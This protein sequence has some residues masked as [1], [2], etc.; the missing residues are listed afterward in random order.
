MV[1]PGEIPVPGQVGQF[2][3]PWHAVQRYVVGTEPRV[4]PP[5]TTCPV[6]RQAAQRPLEREASPNPTP[7]FSPKRIMISP[8]FWKNV[9]SYRIGRPGRSRPC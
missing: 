7:P 6:P 1:P 4:A 8:L 3:V 9:G 5:S 2:I